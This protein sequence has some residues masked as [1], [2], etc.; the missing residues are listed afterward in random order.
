MRKLALIVLDGFGIGEPKPNNAIFMAKTPFLD[1]LLTEYP[2]TA[3]QASGE[4]VGLPEGQIGGS[5]VGH[6]TI[7]AGRVVYQDLPRISKGL[8]GDIVSNKNF[9]ALVELAKQHRLHIIGL[10][11]PGGI[12]S[13]EDHL[14]KL[15]ELLKMNDCMPPYIH[16][17]TDGRDTG[18]H[19][20]RDSIAKLHKCI[21]STRYGRIVTI[22]GRFFGMDRDNNFDRIRKASDVILYG[23]RDGH[24]K[25]AVLPEDFMMYQYDNSVTDEFIE[26]A[27]IDS[28]YGGIA[29]GEPVFFF[30][31][32]SDRM[33]QIVNEIHR[34]LPDNPLMTMTKYDK[35]FPYPVLFEKEEVKETLGEVL[36]RLGHAQVRAAETEKYA[37][38]TYF[39]SGGAEVEFDREV[40]ALEP[41][42]KVKHDE[43]PHM[44]AQEIH[45]NVIELVKKHSP[46]FVLVNF[47]NAD[48][49]GHTGS[50]DAT[51]RAVEKID[52]ELE[53]LFEFLTKKRYICCVTA[54]HGNAEDMYDL[55]TGE[56]NTAHTLNPVP[57]IIYD[58]ASKKNQSL[59]LSQDS[60]NG[61]QM[62]AGTVLELMGLK[63]E[64]KHFSSLIL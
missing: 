48:M 61:L 20:G 59:K 58:P 49:V 46:K 34:S 50:F 64:A 45:A 52:R 16:V 9:I 53:Q 35:T 2:H 60:A 57:F 62:V 55:K 14:F 63:K 8:E 44:K 1:R 21:E 43:L 42:N 51:V 4:H 10:V 23:N 37:H 15:L 25:I 26:P 18:V 12:H 31:F 33:R 5:E 11:S 54:D 24:V 29:A 30:N 6:L 19:S 56:I 13:H 3:L 47:A 27:V 39:F 32:R 36:S 38:I 40:R 28:E 41:S 7:G 22:G 17:I